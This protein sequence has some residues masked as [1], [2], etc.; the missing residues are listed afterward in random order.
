ML[1]TTQAI[2][3]SAIKYAEADLIVKCFTRSSGLKTYLLRGI[4]KSRKGKLRTA[5]FQSGTQLEI[6]AF[7]RD[8]G[9]LESI[10]EAK[11]VHPYRTI[12][13]D[14]VKTTIVLFIAEVLRNAIQEEEQNDE[15]FIYLQKAFLWLDQEPNVANFHLLFLLELTRFLGFYPD[16]STLEK[17]CFNLVTGM[18]EDTETLNS[19]SNSN[20]SVLKDLM[21]IDF[22]ALNQLKL[23]QNRRTEF[24]NMLLGYYEFHLN[25]FK[26]PK[27][28]AVLNSLFS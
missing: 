5:M 22:V 15:L 26:E 7:H 27:S 11:V 12:Y 28:L 24:L 6:V 8:K 25:G 16:T 1:L 13:A 23:N 2:V 20:V 14:I 10:R 3:I 9:T 4:L 18:F 17:P 19:I 21:G